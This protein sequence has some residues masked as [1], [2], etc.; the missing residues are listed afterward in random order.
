[1]P[2]IDELAP[3]TSA[4]DTDEIA[5]SQGGIAR[6]LTRAQLLSGVQPELALPAG[7]LIGRTSAGIGSPETITLGANLQL[8]AGTLSAAAAPYMIVSQPAGIIPSGT[9]LVPLAQ[10]STNIAVTYAQFMAGL[11]GLSG[12][13]ASQ[14]LVT[15]ANAST[16]HTLADSAATAATALNLANGALPIAGGI[17]TGSLT[18]ADDPTAPL[19]AATR[20]YVD[21]LSVL[22]ALKSANL[23]DLPSATAARS[24]IGL[25]SI[26]TQSAASIA[27][28]G[29]TISGLTTLNVP[30]TI[31]TSSN[32]L[33]NN[34]DLIVNSNNHGIYLKSSTAGFSLL[35][36]NGPNVV[37]YNTSG[38]PIWSFDNSLGAGAPF[39]VQVPLQAPWFRTG[40]PTRTL[41]GAAPVS[42]V[43]QG[44]DIGINYKG[45]LGNT[46]PYANSIY[47]ASDTLNADSVPINLAALKINYQYGGTG[48][49]GGRTGM[50]IVVNPIGTVGGSNPF[51]VGTEVFSTS[52][53]P[54]GGTDLGAGAR[55]Q[56]VPMNPVGRA[57]SGATNLVV[58]SG[59]GEINMAV[60]AG[61]SATILNGFQI[62]RLNSDAGT[63][64]RFRAMMFAGTQTPAGAANTIPDM[65]YGVLWGHENHQWSFG[66]SSRMIGW[67]RQSPGTN[68]G[69]APIYP[70][71]LGWGVDLWG[72]NIINQ[73]WRS[74][75]FQIDGTG[76][77]TIG[78]TRLSPSPQGLSVNANG[79]F[80][81]SA[82][83]SGAGV[84]Y[85]IGEYLYG[86]VG[87]IYAVASLSDTGVSAVSIVAIGY[88]TSPPPNPVAVSGGSGS[89]VTLNLSWAPGNGIV[90]GQAG[91]KIGFYGTTPVTKPAVSGS[92]GGNG[93]LA[94]L[95]TALTAYGLVTDTTI[96]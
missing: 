51:Q 4:S 79:Q 60:D 63:V 59:L 47:V 69:G 15:P 7:T 56:I 74:T 13:D 96:S 87:D 90:L 11:T 55:G 18:L 22:S 12:I 86:P 61:A 37:L 35:S 57:Y 16:G 52:N 33:L 20:Q 30:G 54:F 88:A 85:Q 6:K 92:R 14:L 41:S 84:G 45:S 43:S 5:V 91:Q 26:A 42:G 27:I 64:A 76:A 24:N 89:G 62:S 46:E 73:A 67:I 8:V 10:D 53:L 31:T 80:V 2:T 17:L 72:V 65:D 68:P 40:T 81:S 83:I 77:V 29:G 94:S 25:G 19:Q 49:T 3:A 32:A 95:L 93:A 28:T 9:D 70:S 21:S 58:V 23:A 36:G 34:S 50:R 82:S 78:T 38:S 1:M 48:T 71:K 39:Y 44:L 66:A 75:G